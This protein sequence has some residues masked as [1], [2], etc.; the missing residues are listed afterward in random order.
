MARRVGDRGNDAL[1]AAG[2]P[3]ASERAESSYQ[4]RYGRAL[5]LY[6]VRERRQLGVLLALVLAEALMAVACTA[7]TFTTYGLFQ[8][9]GIPDVALPKVA[10]HCALTVGGAAA[11]PRR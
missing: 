3:G 10:G 8:G 2:L 1:D 4:L 6:V 11:G 7:I 9:G 5:A